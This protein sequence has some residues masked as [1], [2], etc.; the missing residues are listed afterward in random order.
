MANASANVTLPA[1][2]PAVMMDEL[3]STRYTNQELYDKMGP[4]S[5][6]MP[7][8]YQDFDWDHCSHAG[9]DFTGI[10]TSAEVT[11]DVLDMTPTDVDEEAAPPSLDDD[12]DDARRLQGARGV[13]MTR[14]QITQFRW[15][16]YK[17]TVPEYIK[18]LF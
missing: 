10:D 4:D 14:E 6:A 3:N 17:M 15:E 8:V 11:D 16:L 12:S 2:S 9:F 5:M 7:Y 13:S 18:D 1:P